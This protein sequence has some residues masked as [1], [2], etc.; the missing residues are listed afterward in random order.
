[1][2]CPIH[3]LEIYN[4]QKSHTF[5]PK[6]KKKFLL[7]FSLTRGNGAHTFHVVK[8]PNMTC[9][10][11]MYIL[12]LRIK[13]VFPF[14]D[15]HTRVYVCMCACLRWTKLDRWVWDVEMEWYDGLWAKEDEAKLPFPFDIYFMTF[16]SSTCTLFF[17]FSILF[18]SLL[19]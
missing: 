16:Y 7:C 11:C 9:P 17:R 10:F 12:L 3:T 5:Y 19:H 18:S 8:L 4:K 15:L 13:K 2:S 14:S 1:M 6:S